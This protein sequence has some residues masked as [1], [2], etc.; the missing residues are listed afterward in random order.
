MLDWLDIQAQRERYND[1]LRAAAHHRRV[2]EARAARPEAPRPH[3]RLIT[4]L[5]HRLV[6]WKKSAGAAHTVAADAWPMS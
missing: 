1:Q 5:R 2:A 4:A 6:G 3:R